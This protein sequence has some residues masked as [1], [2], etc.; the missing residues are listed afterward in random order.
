MNNQKVWQFN[1]TA[2]GYFVVCLVALVM[3]YIPF[4]GWA[5]LMNYIAQWMADNSLINGKKVV[6]RAGYGE[7]LKFVTVGTILMFLTL[8]VYAFWYVP[9]AY[10]FMADHLHYVDDGPMG[11]PMPAA[12]PVNPVQPPAAPLVG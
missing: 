12:A 11:S 1:G 7:A 4:F 6:Y 3:T 9:K 5:F 8:F 2:G 10:R